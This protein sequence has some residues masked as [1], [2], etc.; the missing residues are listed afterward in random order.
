LQANRLSKKRGKKAK[1]MNKRTAMNKKPANMIDIDQM[2]E[3]DSADEV[4]MEEENK[5]GFTQNDD[6]VEAFEDSKKKALPPLKVNKNL[7]RRNDQNA[8]RKIGKANI[9]MKR[10]RRDTKWVLMLYM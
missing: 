8:R 4:S 5:R 2:L 1:M 6:Q 3:Q 7:E 9:Q 10:V